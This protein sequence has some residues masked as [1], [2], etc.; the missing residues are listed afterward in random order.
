MAYPTT[1]DGLTPNMLK[2]QTATIHEQA[3]G[4]TIPIEVLQRAFQNIYDTMDAIDAFKLKALAS[5]KTTVGTLSTE[6]EK[7]KGYI[8]RAEGVAQARIK[9]PE[10]SPFAP[11]ESR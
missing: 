8:A 6:V 10:A 9:G 7:S 4:A 11:I 1:S 5:M 2:S 3:A